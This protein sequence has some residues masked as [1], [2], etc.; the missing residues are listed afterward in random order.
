MLSANESDLLNDQSTEDVYDSGSAGTCAFPFR[1]DDSVGH[2]EKSIGRVPGVGSRIFV[3]I[4][5][6]SNGDVV[7][8]VMFVQI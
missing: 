7:L 1:F 5:I 2:V 3:T 6:K 8:L 4:G